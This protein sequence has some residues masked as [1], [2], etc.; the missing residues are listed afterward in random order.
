MKPTKY[1]F[2]PAVGWLLAS[3]DPGDRHTPAGQSPKGATR[4][5]TRERE[6]LPLQENEAAG[7]APRFSVVIPAYNEA[8]F[9]GSC[10]DSL[11]TQD[12]QGPYEIIVVDNN[13]TDGTADVARSRGVTV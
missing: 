4:V 2:C 11:L 9:L 10:L 5:R 6:R 8:A 13:S 3:D 7:S 1:Q 12:F